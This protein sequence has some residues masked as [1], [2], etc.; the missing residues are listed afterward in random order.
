MIHS[1][2]IGGTRGIGRE[3]VRLFASHGHAVSVIGKRPALAVDAGP[4]NVRYWTMDFTDETELDA[5]LTGI[6]ER[7]KLCNLVFAH[8]Y[9][10]NGDAWEG[11]LTT[12]VREENN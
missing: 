4:D 5:A 3:V 12:R 11:E 7:G 6:V 2:V 8:R 9:K 1:L 10:G